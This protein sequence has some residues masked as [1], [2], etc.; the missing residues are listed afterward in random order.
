M[1]E[2]EQGEISVVE[3]K[4]ARIEELSEQILEASNGLD[5]FWRDLGE[6]LA[7]VAVEVW[8]DELLEGSTELIFPRDGAGAQAEGEPEGERGLQ[9]GFHRFRSQDR[10]STEKAT[11]KFSVRPSSLVHGATLYSTLDCP[12]PMGKARPLDEEPN[13]VRLAALQQLPELLNSILGTQND[14][15]AVVRC[16]LG[17][18]VEAHAMVTSPFSRSGRAESPSTVVPLTGMKPSGRG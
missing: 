14:I 6:R 2:N 1:S 8:A 9:L 10:T 11:W 15:L 3:A 5:E 12:E 16:A 4:M 17:E 13:W 18:P 7:V